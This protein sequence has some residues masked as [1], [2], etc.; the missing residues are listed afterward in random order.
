MNELGEFSEQMHRAV[1][2]YAAGRADMLVTVGESARII[3]EEAVLHGFE[4]SKVMH[5]AD[6]QSA[7]EKLKKQIMKGDVLL[8]KGSQNKARLEKLV[9]ALMK[10]PWQAV[11]LLVRQ[12]REWEKIL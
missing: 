7:A 1:G 3:G 4:A 6:T 9:K 12:E 8:V 11:R 5:F 2:K 10:E